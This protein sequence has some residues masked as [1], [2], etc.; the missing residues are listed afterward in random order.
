MRSVTKGIIL[1]TMLLLVGFT[2]INEELKNSNI[3]ADSLELISQADN[4]VDSTQTIEKKSIIQF[5][6][7]GKMLVSWYGPKFSWKING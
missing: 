3:V 4:Q 7:K 1:L 5:V 6:D 2:V